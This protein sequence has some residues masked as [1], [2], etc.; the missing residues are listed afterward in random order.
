MKKKSNV[1][2]NQKNND[3]INLTPRQSR[4]IIALMSSRTNT[5]AAKIAKVSERTIYEWRKEPEFLAALQAA[6]FETLDA[7]TRRIVTGNAK[8]L[9]ALDDLITKAANESVRRQ[10]AMDWITLLFRFQEARDVYQRLNDL[11]KEFKDVEK[12]HQANILHGSGI[13]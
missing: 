9:D 11:E 6:E 4:T 13:S 12:H 10:A 1:G 8:A 2:G 7:A 3:E 5:E